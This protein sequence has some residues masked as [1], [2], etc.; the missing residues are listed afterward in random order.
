LRQAQR[1]TASAKT[2]PSKTPS[3]RK[4]ESRWLR[5]ASNDL[6]RARG[7]YEPIVGFADVSDA[8]D[9]LYEDRGSADQLRAQLDP[10]PQPKPKPKRPARR[11]TMASVIHAGH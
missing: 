2:T 9:Q 6:D 4:D 5:Q 3:S 10:P 8:L 7:I 1:E 11:R